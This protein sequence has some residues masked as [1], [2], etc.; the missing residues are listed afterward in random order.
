V[1]RGTGPKPESPFIQ[2]II[3]YTLY[4]IIRYNCP[5]LIKG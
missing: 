4:I 2:K 1:P 5:A 3:Y